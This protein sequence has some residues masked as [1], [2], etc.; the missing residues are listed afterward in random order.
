VT[1]EHP[2][3]VAIVTAESET[4]LFWVCEDCSARFETKPV[5]AVEPPAAPVTLSRKERMKARLRL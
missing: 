2:K 1:G 3:I 4:P 5:V